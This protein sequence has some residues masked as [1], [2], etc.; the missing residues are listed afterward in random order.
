M[1]YLTI[2][3]LFPINLILVCAIFI[4]QITDFIECL[5]YKICDWSTAQPLYRFLE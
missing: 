3:S 2:K 1:Y 5:V 4:W